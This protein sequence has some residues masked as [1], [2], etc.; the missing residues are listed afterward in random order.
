MMCETGW[1]GLGQEQE[2][3]WESNVLKSSEQ[4]LGTRRIRGNLTVRK[5][6]K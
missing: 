3:G 6:Y 2:L 1:L 4:R 5:V